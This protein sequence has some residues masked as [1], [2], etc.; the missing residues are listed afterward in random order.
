MQGEILFYFIILTFQSQQSNEVH[1]LPATFHVSLKF[2]CSNHLINTY[3]R[4]HTSV[5][6]YQ[7]EI[8][9]NAFRFGQRE[10]SVYFKVRSSK[11]EL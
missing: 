5:V 9:H 2:P 8:S 3:A 7:D 10:Q 6:S 1:N 11:Y 4:Q